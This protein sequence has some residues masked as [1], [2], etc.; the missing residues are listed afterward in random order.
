MKVLEKRKNAM[1]EPEILGISWKTTTNAIK[2]E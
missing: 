2:G 1:R